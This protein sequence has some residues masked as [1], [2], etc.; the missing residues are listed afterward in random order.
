MCK[1][2][3]KVQRVDI[4]HIFKF[5]WQACCGCIAQLALELQATS[6]MYG[7]TYDVLFDR[8]ISNA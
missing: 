2:N 7:D 1:P 3:V 4:E 8:I 5:W 6:N